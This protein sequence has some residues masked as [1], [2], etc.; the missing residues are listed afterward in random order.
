MGKI[1]GKGKSKGNKGKRKW[2]RQ[3]F[4]NELT[5]NKMEGI[6]QEIKAKG[7]SNNAQTQISKDVTKLFKIDTGDQVKGP[8]DPKRFHKGPLREMAT[9]DKKK[10]DKMVRYG[11]PEDKKDNTEE[12]FDLWGTS[13]KPFKPKP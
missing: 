4:H 3:E 12:V 8:L 9:I 7:F 2:R 6:V 11:I 1:P 13:A 10:V 5:S